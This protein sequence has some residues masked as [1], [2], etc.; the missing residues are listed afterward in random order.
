[1]PCRPPR[2]NAAL[3][4]PAPSLAG[5]H[6]VKEPDGREATTSPLPRSV[7]WYFCPAAGVPSPRRTPRLTA[8]GASGVPTGYRNS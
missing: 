2:D 5:Q 4:R 1:M 8:P 6:D 7:A 3:N